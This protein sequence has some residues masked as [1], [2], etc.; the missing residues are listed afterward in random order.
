MATAQLGMA[1]AALEALVAQ[2]EALAAQ[3]EELAL[4]GDGP[5]VGDGD[6]DAHLGA[7]AAMA[8]PSGPEGAAPLLRQRTQIV[9]MSRDDRIVIHLV[10]T[11]TV[12]RKVY[13]CPNSDHR[14]DNSSWL[15]AG[16]CPSC[17]DTLEGYST[18]AD[19]EDDIMASR[20]HASV[21]MD[22]D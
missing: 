16:D 22:S 1:S 20:A 18:K 19:N 14:A 4:G 6:G 12:V 10:D 9:R 7:V 8:A 2:M 11:T 17:G 21:L 15:F 3:W 5:A 13:V